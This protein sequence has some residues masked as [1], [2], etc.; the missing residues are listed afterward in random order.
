MIE[1]IDGGSC[2]LKKHNSTH[3]QLNLKLTSGGIART[4]S[5]ALII[6]GMSFITSYLSTETVEYSELNFIM[7]VAAIS[8]VP[9]VAI[10]LS[11]FDS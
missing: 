6:G 10:A 9:T 1:S 2:K 3:Q 8:A 5:F 7:T 11:W 4:V